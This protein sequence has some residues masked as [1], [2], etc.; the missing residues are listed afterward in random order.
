MLTTGPQG[1]TF[2]FPRKKVQFGKGGFHIYDRSGGKN[3]RIT[4]GALDSYLPPSI[5]IRGVSIK[6][7]TE[8]GK[9]GPEQQDAI[10]DLL[11]IGVMKGWLIPKASGFQFV[12][13]SFDQNKAW[14]RL[15]SARRTKRHLA[16]E[17]SRGAI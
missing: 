2:S 13:L 1:R 17:Y 4:E 16:V 6:P 12:G 10:E 11:E 15:T 14:D 9:T 7:P 3:K 8:K 5:V